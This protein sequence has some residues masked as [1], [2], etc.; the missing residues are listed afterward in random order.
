M[1]KYEKIDECNITWASKDDIK[2]AEN[3]LWKSVMHMKWLKGDGV[4]LSWFQVKEGED[5]RWIRTDH[6]NQ[7]RF[8]QE[9]LA[10]ECGRQELDTDAYHMHEYESAASGMGHPYVWDRVCGWRDTPVINRLL[11]HSPTWQSVG[12]LPIER[13]CDSDVKPAE[14]APE[15]EDDGLPTAGTAAMDLDPWAHLAQTNAPAA[16]GREEQ[17]AAAVP[18]DSDVWHDVVDAPPPAATAQTAPAAEEAQ[19]PAPDEAQTEQPPE[20]GVSVSKLPPA[21]ADE[22][23][24]LFHKLPQVFPRPSR[25]MS[26]PPSM[27]A[28]GSKRPVPSVRHGMSGLVI[29][30]VQVTVDYPK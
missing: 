11:Y 5:Y 16:S 6:H 18:V 30:W 21:S 2:K 28:P 3:K 24:E 4:T 26:Q 12:A 25:S 8:I 7:M 29:N 9:R 17:P 23:K 13:D 27:N 14:D 20:K 19:P 15:D 10:E 1:Y 22:R